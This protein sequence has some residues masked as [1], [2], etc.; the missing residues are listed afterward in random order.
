MTFS[1]PSIRVGIGT[2]EV[3]EL[4]HRTSITMIIIIIII[5]IKMRLL[6]IMPA[7]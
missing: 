3:S 5:V 1:R 2:K 4:W 7:M 6:I